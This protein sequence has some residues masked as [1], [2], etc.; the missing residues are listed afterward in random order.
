GC[1]VL[2]G[3]AG[4]NN[5]SL[6]ETDLAVTVLDQLRHGHE[7]E[8]YQGEVSLSTAD[9][10][11][12]NKIDS[13]KKESIEIEEEDRKTIA[14]NSTIIKAE[15]EVTI[16]NP[17]LVKDKRVL[18]VEDGPTLTHGEMKIGAGTVAAERLGVKEIID[19]KPYA[20]GSLID[21]FKQYPHLD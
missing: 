10:S 21:T 13:V 9:V 11:I 5:V 14:K 16:D 12:I 17:E 6:Y 19:P 20:V 7:L 4:N 1:D 18:I 3:D 2:L 15:S 8:Y